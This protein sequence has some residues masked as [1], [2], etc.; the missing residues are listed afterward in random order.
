VVVALG[1]KSFKSLGASDKG[2]EIA[3]SFGIKYK[4]FK[5]ALVGLTVQP[6]EA[7]FKKLSGV[8]LQALVK[9]GEKKFK[10]NIL[11]SHRGITG[12]AILNSSLYWEKGK[13]L[14][15]F[16][17]N[18]KKY[19]KYPNKQITTQLPFPKRF[20]K[21]FLLAHGLKDEKLRYFKGIY[22]LKLLESYE[23]APAGT[24]GFEKAEVSKGGVLLDELDDNLE[25]KIK[26]LYFIGEVVDVTGELG[27]YNFQ[28]AF[29]SAYCAYLKLQY[30]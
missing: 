28:W 4:D 27:G 10:G 9:V 24:F 11:F 3:D 17:D 26:G 23:F 18:V 7:W 13:I 22:K 29:S 5:P 8:S 15:S 30:V 16:T 6:S 1:G 25:S 21:T 12:P 20:T 19:L 2:L 14:L